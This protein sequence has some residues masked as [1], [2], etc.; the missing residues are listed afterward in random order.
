MPLL[1]SVGAGDVHVT[2]VAGP[3]DADAPGIAADLAVLHQGAANVG[4]DVDLDL[5]AAVR[6]G[7]EELVAQRSVDGGRDGPNSAALKRT[8]NVPNG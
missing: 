2:V 5:F 6:T 8:L 1:R 7:D 4:L 3:V